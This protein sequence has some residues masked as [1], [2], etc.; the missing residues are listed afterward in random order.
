MTT[1]F[2][3]ETWD[4]NKNY[5]LKNSTPCFYGSTQEMSPKIIHNSIVFMIEMN[6]SKNQIEGIGLIRN[7]PLLDKYYKIYETG[8]FNRYVYKSNYHIDRETLIRYNEKLVR[9]LDHV[10]FK[11]KTHQKRGDGHTTVSDKL[12]KHKMCDGIDV[13]KEIRFVFIDMFGK[14]STEETTLKNQCENIQLKKQH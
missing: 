13:K 12:L 5:R 6:N 4:E 7:N 8:N 10:L 14:K 2:N 1:R 3:N 11:E 9:A